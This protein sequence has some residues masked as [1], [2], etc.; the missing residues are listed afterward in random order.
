MATKWRDEAFD[1]LFDR[2]VVR[3]NGCWEFTGGCDKDGYGKFTVLGITLLAHRVAYDL[4]VGDI[5]DGMKVL[6]TCDNPPC[7]NP[8]HLRLGTA[9]DNSSDMVSRGR[10]NGPRGSRQGQS[11]LT[12]SNVVQIRR[13]LKEGEH[14]QREIARRLKVSHGYNLLN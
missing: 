14:S 5:P 11:K 13:L 4:C 3:D 1:R 7:I 10:T 2:T 8:E 9:L 6:H 12:E